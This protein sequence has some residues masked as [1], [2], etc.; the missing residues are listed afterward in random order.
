MRENKIFRKKNQQKEEEKTKIEWLKDEIK[1]GIFGVFYIL[2]KQ[3]ESTI[4]K[5]IIMHAAL[6]LQLISYS[7]ENSVT[8][9]HNNNIAWR[10]V[11]I[12]HYYFLSYQIP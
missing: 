11:E 12:N 2:L 1:S 7:F 8:I 5:F 10:C 9:S 4:W 3:N 6:F